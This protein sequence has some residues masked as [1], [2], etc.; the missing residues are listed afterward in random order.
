VWVLACR[1]SKLSCSICTLG[2]AKIEKDC[3]LGACPSSRGIFSCSSRDRLFP[4]STRWRDEK[5][6][7]SS[8]PDPQAPPIR[9][10]RHVPNSITTMRKRL[11]IALAKSL[12]R[13]PCCQTVQGA[14]TSS[15]TCD[16]VERAH[17]RARK[18]LAK[19]H[20]N[21]YRQP[22]NPRMETRPDVKFGADV[23][24]KGL[25]TV[26]VVGTGSVN[27]ALARGVRCCQSSRS[28]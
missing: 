16:T 8:R 7:L 14:E 24:R 18:S 6:A 13:C 3:E 20:A 5:P 11:T 10:E 2:C 25:D 26:G 17:Y 12:Y 15:R 9:P 1:F 23:R 28:L 4:Q 27:R 22:H 21:P 19:I